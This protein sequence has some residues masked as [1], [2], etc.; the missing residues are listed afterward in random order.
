LE[1]EFIRRAGSH[2]FVYNTAG[3]VSGT[4]FLLQ[5]TRED[6]YYSFKIDLR[7]TFWKRYIA[8]ASYMRSSSR[9]NQVIDYSLDSPVLSSQV[10]GPFPWDTPNRFISWGYLPLP[11]GFDAGYSLEA[12]TDFRSRY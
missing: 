2:D 12:H 8:T 5:N 4:N 1:T 3:G 6:N 9:S 11:K 10:A 7:R